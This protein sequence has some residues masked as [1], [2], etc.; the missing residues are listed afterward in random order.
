MKHHA[1]ENQIFDYYRR[2]EKKTQKAIKFLQEQV[3][4]VYEKKQIPNIP[5]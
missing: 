4:T 2:N 3:Y 5:K 1:F